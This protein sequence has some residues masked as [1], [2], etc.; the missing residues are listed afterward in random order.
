MEIHTQKVYNIYIMKSYM[1]TNSM[2]NVALFY[3]K[4]HTLSTNQQINIELWLE[5]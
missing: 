5:P 1:S 4:R 2:L 3:I